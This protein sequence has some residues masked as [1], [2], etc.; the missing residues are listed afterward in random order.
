M[1]SAKGLNKA[2]YVGMQGAS[3]SLGT[4][5]ICSDKAE[6]LEEMIWCIGVFRLFRFEMTSLI[7]K[8]ELEPR[9]LEAASSQ[10]RV[11]VQGRRHF[12]I[13]KNQKELKS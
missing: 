11:A 1:A 13:S 8:R 12:G 10:E 5:N 7:M 4:W 6:N 3:E 9:S 2:I